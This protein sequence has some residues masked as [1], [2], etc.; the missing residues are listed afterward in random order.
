[1]PKRKLVITL[2]IGL[3]LAAAVFAGKVK[4]GD[5]KNGIL[6]DSQLGYTLSVPDNWRVKVFDEPTVQRVL[7]VKRNYE[8][9]KMVKDLGGEFTIPEIRIFVRPDSM[10]PMDFLNKLKEA[11]E[12][13]KTEDNII[14]QLDL[15]KTGEFSMMQEIKLDSVPAIQA[16]FKK[17]YQRKL[18]VD[19]NDPHFRQYG[20]LLVQNEHLVNELYLFK[21]NGQLYVI[22]AFSEREF[23][24]INKE[25]FW[26]I[27]GSIVFTDDKSGNQVVSPA[28]SGK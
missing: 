23:Y 10:S 4:S 21:R 18:E 17:N 28:E 15:V 25:E 20:G 6:T 24:P 8:I 16:I 22:H 26:K 2:I 11:V 12:V 13:H 5:Y 3:T 9:N 7:M 19:P 1:M 27:I 14:S